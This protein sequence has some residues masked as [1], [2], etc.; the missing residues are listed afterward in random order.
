M[1]ERREGNH[2]PQPADDPLLRRPVEGPGVSE[3]PRP[4]RQELLHAGDSSPPE[5]PL[6]GHLPG[7][8]TPHSP[9][10]G[11]V[12]NLERRPAR[13]RPPVPRDRQGRIAELLRLYHEEYPWAT[14]ADRD[15]PFPGL[16][17]SMSDEQLA[18]GIRIG[19][20]KRHKLSED[21]RYRFPPTIT[22]P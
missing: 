15:D 19:R 22:M 5:L 12:D 13:R 6:P 2:Q 17:A 8:A 11:R 21:A 3:L 4:S 10:A 20:S 16:V 7:E 14:D 9:P 1:V 18:V